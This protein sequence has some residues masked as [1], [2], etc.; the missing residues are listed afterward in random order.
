MIIKE[1]KNSDPIVLRG[2]E[3]K[4]IGSDKKTKKIY[5][6]RLNGLRKNQRKGVLSFSK[7]TA[8]RNDGKTIIQ[9]MDGIKKRIG[10]QLGNYQMALEL[11]FSQHLK[12]FLE[13]LL[14]DSIL[15]L[16][17]KNGKIMISN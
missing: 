13:R 9:Q 12:N 3:Q 5:Q 17:L 16:S 1:Y 6:S 15:Y 4:P 8:N 7:I 2:G 10:R 11:F 14:E